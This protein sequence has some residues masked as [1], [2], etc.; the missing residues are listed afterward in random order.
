MD[1]VCNV[2][3]RQA[4]EFMSSADYDALAAQVEAER[5][6]RTDE[7]RAEAD[8]YATL[9]TQRDVAVIAEATMRAERDALATQLEKEKADHRYISELAYQDRTQLQAE[10]DALAQQLQQASREQ[11]HQMTLLEEL[12][13]ELQQVKAERDSLKRTLELAARL[14]KSER[15]FQ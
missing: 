8:V 3:G 7:R 12:R 5:K 2:V 1:T 14:E 6:Q 13:A 4:D 11:F 15:R 10:R 9:A